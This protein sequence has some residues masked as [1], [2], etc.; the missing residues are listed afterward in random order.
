[1]QTMTVREFRDNLSQI[2]K[3]GKPVEIRHPTHPVIVMPKGHYEAMEIDL[4]MALMDVAEMTSQRKYT[5]EEVDAMLAQVKAT[6]T[7]KV[8]RG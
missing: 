8:S 2:F 1:M 7:K 5:S 6:P 4:M 3:S